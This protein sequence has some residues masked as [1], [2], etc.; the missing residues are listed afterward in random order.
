M[1]TGF[2]VTWLRDDG[3][4]TQL[5]NPSAHNGRP[6]LVTFAR[7]RERQSAVLLIG[8]L[9]YRTDLRARFPE[10]VSKAPAADAAL[11]LAVY[12]HTGWPGLARLEGEFAIVLWDG[13]RQRLLAMRD[14]L[15]SWPLFWTV[16]PQEIAVS[17]SLAS[18][19]A[20]PNNRTPDLEYLAEYLATPF[21]RSEIPC[22]KT[23]FVRIQRVM[24]GTGVEFS[25]GGSVTQ[26]R[27]WNWEE[28]I[29]SAVEGT[30]Q[31]VGAGLTDRLRAAVRERLSPGPVAAH[32]S[33]G[34][35]RQ[36]Q[37]EEQRTASR[38]PYRGS[39]GACAEQLFAL[40][41]IAQSAPILGYLHLRDAVL[42]R[43][44]AYG[45]IRSRGQGA[46]QH[47]RAHRIQGVKPATP[48]VE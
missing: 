14:P 2:T 41:I 7:N 22:E 4:Q 45:L 12:Q 47:V 1:N 31:E 35:P 43:E 21:L 16:R 20:L 25:P 13:M 46:R 18:L 26:R 32:L 40:E 3:L 15:G 30:P 38:K 10:A 48:K 17:T 34:E 6:P 42:L 8:S 44:R 24:P 28:H 19:T 36:C 9:F 5:H 37:Q 39:R 11:A 27:Y 33:G 29:E 23:A